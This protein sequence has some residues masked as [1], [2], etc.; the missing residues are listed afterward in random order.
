MIPAASEPAAAPARRQSADVSRDEILRVAADCF[1]AHGC[2]VTTITDIARAL[3]ATKGRIYH[4]FRS[5][6]ELLGAI[7]L[8]SV[9]LTYERV[10]PAFDATGETPDDKFFAMARAHVMA[11]MEAMS[12][13]R[14]VVE[15]LGH[16]GARSTT[17]F[18]REL[19]AGIRERQRDYETMFRQ[20]LNEGIRAGLFAA[21]SPSVT[22]HSVLHLLHSPVHWYSPRAG[23]TDQDR[24]AIATRL[25]E[26]A[27]GAV[28]LA[29][30]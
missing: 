7:R 24:T 13:H 2:D 15:G 14:V 27:H 4:H 12:F 26:M 28:A 16:G 21:P 20:V 5:K 18:E 22:L 25:A 30:T 23:E 9:T 8:R 29:N 11:M 10:R 6:G 19:Q 1:A 3:G 17:E